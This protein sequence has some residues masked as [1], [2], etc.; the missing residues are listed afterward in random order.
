VEEGLIQ[1]LRI[2]GQETGV[3]EPFVFLATK[4]TNELDYVMYLMSLEGIIKSI[5]KT[6]LKEENIFSIT[7]M[8]RE[9]ADN[10]FRMF[11]TSNIS[12]NS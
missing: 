10:I 7:V 5:E 3:E 6:G 12:K 4:A 8:D 1:I 9:M 2:L 11:V